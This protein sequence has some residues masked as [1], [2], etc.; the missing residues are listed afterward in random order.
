MRKVEAT[1]SIQS[2]PENI[3]AAFVNPSMLAEW[4]QVERAFIDTRVDGIYALTWQITNN[5]FGYMSV[6]NIKT[7]NP[8]MQLV[9]DNFTYFNP[10]KSI[11]GNMTLTIIA[12]E[13]GN[14]TALYLCQE[15]YQAGADW[16]WYYQ[17]VTEAWPNVL[18][19][20]KVYLENRN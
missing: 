18:Q 16:D 14:Q 13:N 9:I 20:L 17:V 1:I 8:N 7:Y 19:D 15:G 6:G 11:L 4:W 5:G 12:K 10:E 3:I 2:K